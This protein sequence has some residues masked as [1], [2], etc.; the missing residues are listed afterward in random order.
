MQNQTTLS[1]LRCNPLFYGSLFSG[2]GGIDIGFDRAG[3]KCAWQVE[4]D[5]FARKVLDNHW[6]E[7][8][9]H[10]DI[11][12]FE[13]TY[14][15]VVCGGFPCQDI[16]VAGRGKGLAG[17][18][19]GLWREMLR[20]VRTIRPRYIV[21]ENVAALLVRGLDTVLWDIASL[22]YDAEWSTV[23]ACSLGAPHTRD[24]LFIVAYRNEKRRRSLRFGNE[25]QNGMGARLNAWQ[26]APR[27]KWRDL[28][29]WTRQVMETGNG[30][31]TAAERSGMDDGVSHRLDRLGAC[32]NAVVPQIGNLIGEAIMTHWME[33]DWPEQA[34]I[35]CPEDT[36][37]K[38]LLR[39]ARQVSS[40]AYIANDEQDNL[41]VE[42]E[43]AI[44][45]VEAMFEDTGPQAMGWVGDNGLP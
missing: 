12:T 44:E 42:F 26:A 5:K 3:L 15:D 10:E 13:P 30:I 28:E 38:R 32:G 35:E 23:S 19:S 1:P 27:G 8:P 41:A 2:I 40:R 39:A 33:G 24:R 20:V 21:I 17:E 43:Q 29:C 6:P 18:R 25:R 16:S 14:V 45:D 7:V 4:I 11:R 22:G 37:I 36:A 34:E 9:K 31:T